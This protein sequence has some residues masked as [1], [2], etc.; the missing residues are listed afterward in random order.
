MKKAK[1]NV[2]FK[3]RRRKIERKGRETHSMA[4]MGLL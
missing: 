1:E 3:M 4:F 2:W